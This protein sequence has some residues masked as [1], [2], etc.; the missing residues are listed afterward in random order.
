MTWL[1]DGNFSSKNKMIAN[2]DYL[3][4]YLI[5]I[6]STHVLRA[7]TQCQCLS[8]NIRTSFSRNFDQVVWQISRAG[9]STHMIHTNNLCIRLIRYCSFAPPPIKLLNMCTTNIDCMN[10]LWLWWWYRWQFDFNIKWNE[11]VMF[12]VRRCWSPSSLIGFS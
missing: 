10:H 5:I 4:N 12:Y 1:I 9:C 2:D 8:I 11:F 6:W 7:G 3:I